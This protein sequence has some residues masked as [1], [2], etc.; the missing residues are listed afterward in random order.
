MIRKEPATEQ[1]IDWWRTYT[2]IITIWN[3][4]YI[5][6]KTLISEP[7]AKSRN[8]LENFGIRTWDR[9]AVFSFPLWKLR[10]INLKKTKQGKSIILL[11]NVTLTKSHLVNFFFNPKSRKKNPTYKFDVC[12]EKLLHPCTVQLIKTNLL[13]A[14]RDTMTLFT[15]VFWNCCLVTPDITGHVLAPLLLLAAHAAT[16]TVLNHLWL[17][18]YSTQH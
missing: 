10:R 17:N 2:R 4:R 15:A 6:L 14:K 9:S 12:F 7:N 3:F 13:P 16:L 18:K 1:S 8:Q 5:A 11:K